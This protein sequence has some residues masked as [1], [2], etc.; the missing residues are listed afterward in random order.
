MVLAFCSSSP[1]MLGEGFSRLSSIQIAWLLQ[2]EELNGDDIGL[3]Q[4]Y[5]ADKSFMQIPNSHVWFSSSAHN[6]KDP[7]PDQPWCP[8][9]NIEYLCLSPDPK[10]IESPLLLPLCWPERRLRKGEGEE[11]RRTKIIFKLL[12]WVPTMEQR[13]SNKDTSYLSA[14]SLNLVNWRSA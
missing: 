3:V 2:D 13:L 8:T 12:L 1:N 6:A 11:R 5:K 7:C 9:N 4:S 10:L 14:F